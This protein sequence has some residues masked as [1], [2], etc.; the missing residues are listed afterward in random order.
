VSRPVFAF[1]LAG[2]AAGCAI[3]LVRAAA[4]VDAYR[5]L[6]S[7]LTCDLLTDYS[8]EVH[9]REGKKLAAVYDITHVHPDRYYIRFKRP[10]QSG[11][12]VVR[13]R[14]GSAQFAC[15]AGAPLSVPEMG[16]GAL[17]A[18]GDLIRANY[19]LKILG[20]DYIAGREA[21]HLRVTSKYGSPLA[22][23]FWV[24]TRKC[25]VLC[26]REL[27]RMGVI[28]YEERFN[29][30][31]FAPIARGEG[32]LVYGADQPGPDNAIP[33]ARRM[34]PEDLSKELGF[35]VARP[36]RMPKGYVLVGTYLAECP[37][38]CGAKAAL[39]R[40]TDGL[41][42][43]S[44]FQTRHHGTGCDLDGPS[45]VSVK[46]GR[47]LVIRSGRE[48]MAVVQKSGLHVIA[49]GDLPA[50]VLS[51]IADTVPVAEASAAG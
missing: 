9:I 34:K 41:S 3:W 27:D 14:G 35:A 33:L 25:L 17:T 43:V 15:S 38:G 44:V 18:L 32:G 47:C 36:K 20:I 49:V 1:A 51:A 21:T 6:E 19:R 2:L 16:I 29:T 45:A 7:A 37:R 8:G 46:A 12:I 26:S 48:T 39:C 40:Y 24:D 50:N 4:G 31:D 10:E 23:E 28:L 42:S 5:T 13:G 11:L 30:V 22:R